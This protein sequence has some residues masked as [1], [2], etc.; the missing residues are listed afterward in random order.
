MALTD[1]LGFVALLSGGLLMTVYGG[2]IVW[3]VRKGGTVNPRLVLA[4]LGMIGWG[5]TLVFAGQGSRA[6]WTAIVVRDLLWVVFITGELMRGRDPSLRSVSGRAWF[7]PSLLS[8]AVT[9]VLVAQLILTAAP[10]IPG[11]AVLAARESSFFNGTL[12]ALFGFGALLLLDLRARQVRSSGGAAPALRQSG[13]LA[14][15]WAYDLGIVVYAVLSGTSALALAAMQPVFALLIAPLLALTGPSESRARISRTMTYRAFALMAVIAY[16]FVLVVAALLVRVSGAGITTGAQMLFIGTAL[17]AGPL[18]LRSHRLRAW[19][20]VT[21]AKNFFEHR[22]DYREAWLRF[23]KTLRVD[24]SGVDLSVRIAR[25]IAELAGCPG[26]I[27]Y[28]PGA[29]GAWRSAGHWRGEATLP[30]AEPLTPAMVDQLRGSGQII[31]IDDLRTSDGAQAD[32]L[33]PLADVA[34]AWALLPLHHAGEAYGAVLV[35]RP[36][37]SRALDWEDFDVLRIGGMHTASLLAEAKS[38]AALADARRFE[39]FNQRFAFIL[40]DI[41][42][43]ASQ[44]S[45]LASNA[46]RHG[47]SPAFREDMIATMGTAADRL[48]NL[49]IKLGRG[50]SFA[51]RG[52]PESSAPGEAV[53]DLVKRAIGA[54]SATRTIAVEVSAGLMLMADT[55]RLEQALRQLIANACEASPPDATV[56][57]TAWADGKTLLM[58]VSDKG[59]GMTPDFIATELFKP[60]VSSKDHGFGLGAFE[61]M[62]AVQALGGTLSV[63]SEPGQGTSMTVRV[64][65]VLV[66]AA[67]A[68]GA[69]SQGAAA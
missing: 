64:P 24:D 34:E 13:A 10:Y 27:L 25:S 32:T 58:S 39:E 9:A 35:L 43:V 38:Q 46:Q 56:T 22:F 67:A 62:T 37:V 61:A 40:H 63:V 29:D 6:V 69:H 5:V 48:K 36:V 41:K 19:L 50:D 42:N 11:L 52:D 66:D 26:A 1:I 55:A 30:R 49:T 31:A 3:T 47:D 17:V 18:L 59:V 16:A 53:S 23:T 44:L 7:G 12:H 2:L 20:A 54:L 33:G 57:V 15:L 21:V 45:L 51:L 14:A 28:T 4:L 68:A 60:F 8:G 65:G